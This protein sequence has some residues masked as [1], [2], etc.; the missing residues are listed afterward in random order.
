MAEW[1]PNNLVTKGAKNAFYDAIAAAPATWRTHCQ[2]ETS[3][4]ATE[5]YSFPGFMPDPR[6]FSGARQLQ[7]LRDFTFNLTNNEYELSVLIGRKWFEDD[8]TGQINR[9]MVEIAEVFE[10]FKES[11]FA[12]LLINGD[13]SGNNGWDGTTFYSD[14]RAIGDA[15][16]FDNNLTGAAA[17]GTD[18]TAGEMLG[19]IRDCK[20]AMWEAQ[21][22]QG[23]P[24]N[25]Q[26]VS[27]IAL[28]VPADF[29]KAAAE[30]I[31]STLISNTSNV[32]GS[33]LNASFTVS[34]Y[35]TS[36][37]EFYCDAVGAAR[38]PFIYQERTPVEIQMLTG[39]EDV[40]LHNG[41]MVLC[42][43]RYIMTYG[44][45]RRSCL[46]TVT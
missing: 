18:P 33:S 13:V 43:Q 41:V 8:Q 40:A 23:R 19:F 45:P 46:Y 24:F 7:G 14:T 20:T 16:N 9:R 12:T 39:A 22:D 36:N 30:A 42:R 25:N 1:R 15:A 26:A 11:Q 2:I 44:E 6:T 37:A 10:Q 34:P 38:M 4:T 3:D 27:A 28:V 5:T 31:N 21:D 35:L 29:E 17:T 32:Y